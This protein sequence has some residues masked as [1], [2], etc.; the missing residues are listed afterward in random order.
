MSTLGTGMPQFQRRRHRARV[1]LDA[2]DAEYPHLWPAIDERR[3]RR[4]R[5]WPRW[6]YL[7]ISEAGGLGVPAEIVAALAAWRMTLAI[8][9]VEQ[10]QPGGPRAE[11]LPHWCAYLEPAG[12]WVHRDPTGWRAVVDHGSLDALEPRL[13]DLA[14]RADPVSLALSSALSSRLDGR[15]TPGNPSPARLSA[16][17][18]IR[19]ARG[20][21]VWRATAPPIDSLSLPGGDVRLQ[22]PAPNDPRSTNWRTPL[23]LIGAHQEEE[24]CH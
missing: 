20:L 1:I 12:A 10:R 11:L 16:G 18:A 14:L 17:W 19:P 13:I 22:H 21:S 9:R 8:Y 6:C 24:Q 2:L 23:A 5:T 4:A 15:G 3:R 7:P